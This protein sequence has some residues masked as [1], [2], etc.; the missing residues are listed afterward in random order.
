MNK[1]LM[2]AVVAT[3]TTITSINMVQANQPAPATVA[4]IDTALNA[5]LAEFKDKIVHEVC[6]LEWNSC[7]NGSNFMEGQGAASMPLSQM[8]ANGFDHG[9]KMAHASILTNPNIKIVF[10][11]IVGAT[12]TGARQVYNE[13]TVRNALNWVASNKDRFN[14]T[15]VGLSQGTH[16]ILGRLPNYCPTTQ[17]TINAISNLNSLGVPVF[18]AAG[19]SRDKQRVSWPACISQAVTVSASTESDGE[20]IYTNYDVN[21]TDMFA[22]ARLRLVNPSGYY[23]IEEGTSVSTQVAAAIYVGLKSKNPTLSTQQ[24]LN[25]MRQTSVPLKSRTATGFIVKKEALNG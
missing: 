9:T 11:R 2:A 10:I 6:I 19:N 3:I 17:N 21:I 20:A 18:I 7:A 22:L 25:L 14:I 12:S 4:I 13:V 24:V 23:F 15:A 5:N 16:A 8:V 1:K